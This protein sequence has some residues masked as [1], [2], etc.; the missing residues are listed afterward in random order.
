LVLSYHFGFLAKEGGSVS[1]WVGGTGGLRQGKLVEQV[2]PARQP[3]ITSRGLM[4]PNG[5]FPPPMFPNRTCLSC[6]P[7]H[8]SPIFNAQI[9]PSPDSPATVPTLTSRTPSAQT[10]ARTCTPHLDTPPQPFLRGMGQGNSLSCYYLAIHEASRRSALS[11]TYLGPKGARGFLMA[12]E[13]RGC[14]GVT[15]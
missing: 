6:S 9:L 7:V 2:L 3:S 11:N 8:L 10:S 1:T 5:T 14:G 13:A 4:L 15:G 12:N